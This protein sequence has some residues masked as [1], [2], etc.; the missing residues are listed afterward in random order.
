V[1]VQLIEQ[2]RPD[3]VIYDT[4]IQLH[5]I[6]ENDN[7]LMK[8]VMQQIR[9]ITCWHHAASQ[10]VDVAHIVVH[11]TRKESAGYREALS[12]ELMRGAGSVHGAADIVV[13]ARNKARNGASKILEVHVSSRSS[14]VEDFELHRTANLTH[15]WNKR[16][17]V[18]KAKE[19]PE[20]LKEKFF[21]AAILEIL[22]GGGDAG[23]VLDSD[24]V[25]GLVEIKKRE[26]SA[27]FS[28]PKVHRVT[29]EVTNLLKRRQIEYAVDVAH[30]NATSWKHY[31]LRPMMPGIPKISQEL[32]KTT[33]RISKTPLRKRAKKISDS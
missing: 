28:V 19:T 23:V 6:N 25:C 1:I 13:L 15:V 17:A 27:N 4:L 30:T 21:Q 26:V 33:Q 20:A 24:T 7:V 32:K 2:E 12:P 10:P 29:K 18:D 16:T 31:P 22:E 14:D 8:R 11:H 9:S 5:S 3:V